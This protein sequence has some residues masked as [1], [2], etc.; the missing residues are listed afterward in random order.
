[1][2]GISCKDI[3]AQFDKEFFEAEIRLLDDASHKGGDANNL[4]TL[5]NMT[6][7]IPRVEV[8]YSELVQ[9]GKL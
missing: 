9:V 5:T 3:Y 7:L 6:K 2:T 4:L 1:M 8:G